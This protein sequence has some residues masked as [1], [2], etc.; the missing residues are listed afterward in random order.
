MDL[1]KHLFFCKY[2]N[3]I[4]NT[5]NNTDPNNNIEFKQ[6][7][8]VTKN[9][10]NITNQI[11]KIPYFFHNFRVIT[12]IKLV[13]DLQQTQMNVTI[14]KSDHTKFIL[15]YYAEN[16]GCY[17]RT[18]Y[19]TNLKTPKQVI[20][21]TMESYLHLLKSLIMLEKNKIT[22]LDL[23]P[24]TVI[25]ED[26]RPFLQNFE[27][28]I[29]NEHIDELYITAIIKNIKDFTYKPLEIHLLFYLIVNDIPSLSHSLS[30]E[31]GNHFIETM[32]LLQLFSQEHRENYKKE[33]TAFLNSY[34]N[35]SRTHIIKDIIQYYYTW[36]NYSV[37][38]LYLHIFGNLLHVFSLPNTFV[39][40]IVNSLFQ[41]ISII[42]SKR[43]RL[44]NSLT[45]FNQLFH[46]HTDWSCVNNIPQEKMDLLDEVL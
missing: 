3:S 46:K 20:L 5:T 7:N 14:N 29:L 41:N 35:Q 19:L 37:S 24:S 13:Q 17:L 2:R 6:I 21:H 33:C 27:N 26:N 43:E 38:I 32:P 40:E 45:N 1:L 36:D 28:S 10:I 16:N 30:Y 39:S 15:I 12:Q 42:P 22:F 25:I 11:K 18:Y 23:S 4:N 31:I 44:Q 34:V 8:F 9:E